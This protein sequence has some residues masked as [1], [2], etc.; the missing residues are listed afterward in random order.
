MFLL[1]IKGVLNL[2]QTPGAIGSRTGPVSTRICH[3]VMVQRY[4]Y[5]MNKT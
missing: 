3:N 5:K 4:R 2:L 1:Q